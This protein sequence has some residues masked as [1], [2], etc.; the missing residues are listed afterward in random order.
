MG[1]SQKQQDF[2][3]QAKRLIGEQL[4]AVR[5]FE[6]P[7]EDHKPYW[8][9]KFFDSL[10]QGLD[11]EFEMG[12]VFSITWDWSFACYGLMVHEGSLATMLS[13]YA[14]W[15]VSNDS[16]WAPLIGGKIT[17]VTVYWAK[18]LRESVWIPYPLV[19]VLRFSTGERVFLCAAMNPYETDELDKGA[20]EVT[21]I[22]SEDIAR[23]YHV[24]PYGRD[25]D[26]P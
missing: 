10:D 4:V 23:R 3:S 8:K 2:E 25:Y 21:V 17:D 14:M 26:E 13:D 24:G 6:C 1:L 20:D 19:I 15:D 12:R 22:F 7:N 9:R 16:G 11:L 5:Y 18:E